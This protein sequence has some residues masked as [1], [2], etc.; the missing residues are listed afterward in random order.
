MVGGHRCTHG[1]DGEHD[2][3]P[4]SKHRFRRLAPHDEGRQRSVHGCKDE[5]PR[6]A[7]VEEAQQLALDHGLDG[8]VCRAILAGRS[9]L[10]FSAHAPCPAF[11]PAKAEVYADGVDND[12]N[13]Q[14]H[15]T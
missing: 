5:A 8:A 12:Y 2:H 14:L 10:V 9:R 11:S 4:A 13:T 1:R 3:E 15:G 7:L 6:Q